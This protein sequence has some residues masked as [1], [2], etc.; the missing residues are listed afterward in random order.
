[1]KPARCLVLVSLFL[2]LSLLAQSPPR[3]LKVGVIDTEKILRNSVT[4]KAALADLKRLQD[5]KEAEVVVRQKAIKDLQAKISEGR[6]TLGQ[7]KLGAM[8]KQLE[9]MMI[10]L[11]RFQDDATRDLT[12]KRDDILADVDDKVMPV[13]YQLAKEQSYSF[14]FRKFESGL[15]FADQSYDIT[16]LIIRRLDAAKKP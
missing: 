3:P 15:I 5:Q 13:I 12:K 1:M 10:G 6:L 9:D 8:E 16:D 7:A 2:S 14:I 4:G 11:R